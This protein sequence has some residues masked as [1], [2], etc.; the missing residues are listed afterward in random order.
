MRDPASRFS[1]ETV[2][3]LLRPFEICDDAVYQR[4]N[5]RYVAR[6]PALHLPRFAP[7]GYHL[8]GYLIDG[9][10]GRLINDDPTTAH[11]NDSS[12]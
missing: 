3:H 9:N 5:Y 8:S 1:D 4:P 2:K 10:D 12:G 7:N 11:R 6:F